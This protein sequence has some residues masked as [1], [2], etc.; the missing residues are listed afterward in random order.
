MGSS[1]DSFYRA[2]KLYETGGE[3]ALHEISRQKLPLRIAWLPR[4]NTPLPRWPSSNR[5]GRKL[6]WPMNCARRP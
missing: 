2:K 3:G 1:R 4:W 6:A 5:P